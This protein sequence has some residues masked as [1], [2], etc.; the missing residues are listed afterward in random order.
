MHMFA[1]TE[2][3]PGHAT[4]A[5]GRDPSHTD[6]VSNEIGV[7]DETAPLVD[8]KGDPAS[9]RRL[10]GST[11]YDWIRAR[12]TSSHGMAVSR[13][14]RG[15]ILLVGRNGE[16][17][18]YA[19]ASG[20]FTTSSFYRDRIPSWAQ[21]VNIRLRPESYLGRVWDLSA[22]ASQYTEPD[23]V[24]YENAGID[25][26]FPHRMT[27]DE[28]R[29]MPQLE[30]Y[31]WMDSVTI[32]AALEGIRARNLGK[33]G[34]IDYLGLSL[35]TTDA[36]GHGY[37]ADSRELH[38]HLLRLDKWLGWFL[39]SLET[40]VPANRTIIAMS[41]DHGIAFHPERYQRR[42]LPG[43]RI[44]VRDAFD[45]F[46]RA[47]AARL[48]KAPQLLWDNGLLIADLSAIRRARIDVDSLAED[49]AKRLRAVPG[50]RRVFTPASLA[51]AAPTDQDAALWR[52]NLPQ[53]FPWLVAALTA[54][55]HAF[56]ARTIAEHGTV[57]RETQR[58]PMLFVVPGRSRAVIDRIV[59]TVDF[60]PTIG[61]V[62][63][64]RPIEKVD[65]VVLSEVVRP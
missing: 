33:R 16:A 1:I 5:T 4:L 2:T 24:W 61:A 10:R 30:R 37:G 51:A 22:P 34:T 47:L 60:A 44:D 65:G 49:A 13:K 7:L 32:S 56:S 8:A 9:P 12:Y 41:S 46:I 18:W 36:V 27:A 29:V 57:Q 58:V 59:E 14:D 50:V 31:P 42:G 3:A 55:G 23:S 11:L 35:S 25:V 62:L 48:G 15:S 43:D 6:I 64:V 53:D 40:Q 17:V 19:G 21:A 39:D 63:N 38:D 26:V 45:P 28:A 52:R 20:K 54:P